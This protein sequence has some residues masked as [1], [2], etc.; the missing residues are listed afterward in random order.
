MCFVGPKIK[1]TWKSKNL[2]SETFMQYLC[3]AMNLD[4]GETLKVPEERLEFFGELYA[5]NARVRRI[6]RSQ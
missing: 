1:P 2:R 5:P 6:E 3:R 4:P